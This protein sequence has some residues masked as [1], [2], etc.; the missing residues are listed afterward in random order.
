MLRTVRYGPTAVR[1]PH[2]GIAT[3]TFDTEE[4]SP[5]YIRSFVAGDNFHRMLV[6][7]GEGEVAAYA[8]TYPF[9]QRKA[10]SHMA[11]MMVYVHPAW[12]RRRVGSFLL[13]EI[14]TT[15]FLRGLYTLLVLINTENTFVHRGF[16]DL[17]YEDKGE[18]AGV[19]LKF[20]QRHS[21]AIYQ[22]NVQT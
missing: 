5:D 15:D 10:Y 13:G 8:G 6:A 16:E 3:A 19:A 9:S 18:M 21:L 2:Y 12:Q 17:E 22:R 4:K 20:G 11:K 14:H 1:R 7:K